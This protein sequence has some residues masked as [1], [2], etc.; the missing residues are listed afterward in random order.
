MVTSKLEV[1]V[2]F[3][4]KP[5]QKL[6]DK[7]LSELKSHDGV[8]EAVYKNGAIMVET[9]LPNATVLD[10]VARTSGKRTVLQ[11]FGDTQSAVAMVTSQS[12]CSAKVVGVV[13]FQ[14]SSD[15]ALVADGSV[16]GL[17]TGPHGL[18]VHDVGD[19]SRGCQSIGEHFNPYN[20][21]HGGPND[22]KE[23][24]HAGDLGNIIADENGRATFR[25]QDNLLKIWDIIGRSVAITE[26]GDDLGRG[27][28]PD[29]KVNGDSG[30]PIA[31][32]IIARSAGVFQNPKRICACDGVVVWD[33]RDK[34]LAGKGRREGCCQK[35]KSGGCCQDGKM[36]RQD[37]KKPCCKV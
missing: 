9:T 1:L 25:I 16:D 10:I 37:V 30:K 36:N 14:Q 29:S 22:P 33:E 7:T 23:L 31:C 18:H 34:P 11:G 35:E 13:R 27:T 5:E 15:G 8:K 21:P 12:C 19:L 26:R 2:D 17:A 32:G 24:R 20:S 28:C 4:G 6:L 3:G